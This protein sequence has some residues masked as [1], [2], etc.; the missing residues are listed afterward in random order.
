M[1]RLLKA[2]VL[3]VR[4]LIEKVKLGLWK[5]DTTTQRDFIYNSPLVKNV[6]TDHGSISKA[7]FVLYNI[8]NKDII[9]PAIT[10]W[11]NTDTGDYNIHDGKQRTLSL[12]YFITGT[13]MEFW[14]DNNSTCSFAALRSETQEKLLN[15]QLVVQYNEGTTAEEKE[16]FY[17]V[18]SNAI[19]LTDYE[20]LRSV[21][22]GTHMYT[23]EDYINGLFLDGVK[24]VERGEQAYKFLLAKYDISD[25]KQ[26]GSLDVSRRR[27]RDEIAE[28]ITAPF[29]PTDRGFDKMIELFSS[30]SQIKFV[31]SKGLSEDA[32]L[33]IAHY[34]IRN[35]PGRTNDVVEL[36]RK[37]ARVR[38]DILKWPLDFNKGSIE[39]HKRFIIAYLDEG[40]WLDPRRFFD[41]SEKQTL[42]DTYG[43]RCQYVDEATGDQCTEAAYKKLQVDHKDPWSKGGRTTLANAQL[44]CEHHNKSKGNRN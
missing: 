12:Y 29:D 37:S 20:N 31:G 28:R 14:V 17:E 13:L 26:A 36:Y 7:A 25:A 2:E 9:L 16:N 44:L 4:E 19:N 11:H 21:S 30:L 35:Y 1:A 32:A 38:N 39:T 24:K 6:P 3:T 23:Y 15:Y 22:F 8:L 34:V 5:F 10:I 42:I 33:A 43:S 41:D 27:L 40:L 18:N